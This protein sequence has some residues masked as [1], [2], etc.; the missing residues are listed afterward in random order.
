[1]VAHDTRGVVEN[2]KLV[3]VVGTMEMGGNIQVRVEEVNDELQVKF[4][5]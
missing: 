5:E 2:N 1:M 3:V 4:C